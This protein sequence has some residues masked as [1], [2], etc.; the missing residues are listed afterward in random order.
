MNLWLP[1]LVW[2]VGVAVG[3]IEPPGMQP[4]PVVNHEQR[5][6]LAERQRR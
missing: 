4:I 5:L 3:L 1:N 6:R 2:Q